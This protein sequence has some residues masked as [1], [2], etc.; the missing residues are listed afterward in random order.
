[1]YCLKK[2]KAQQLEDDSKLALRNF[3]PS[4]WIIREKI[5][6]FAVDLEIE[7]VEEERPQTFFC[8]TLGSEWCRHCR[9]PETSGTLNSSG[10]AT[11]HSCM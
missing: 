5:P 6:D 1:M 7:I 3:L 10:H 11:L 8:Y 2:T 9:S 4:S